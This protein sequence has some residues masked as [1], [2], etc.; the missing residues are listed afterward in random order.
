M[1]K[2]INKLPIIKNNKDL[3]TIIKVEVNRK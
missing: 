2:K 1:K 3:L